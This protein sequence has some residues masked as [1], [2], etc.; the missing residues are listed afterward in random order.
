VGGV[1]DQLRPERRNDL[2]LLDEVEVDRLEE[3]LETIQ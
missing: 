3:G 2:L 1:T